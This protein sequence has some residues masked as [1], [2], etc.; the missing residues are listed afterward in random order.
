MSSLDGLISYASNEELQKI[1]YP[2]WIA[3]YIT[4]GLGNKEPVAFEDFLAAVKGPEIQEKTRTAKEI[5][6]D[7][8]KIVQRYRRKEE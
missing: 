8:M 1:A 3:H 2:L 7:F 4:S 6:D 5:Q